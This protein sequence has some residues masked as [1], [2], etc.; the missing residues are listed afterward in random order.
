MSLF[1]CSRLSSSCR[2]RWAC[3]L[4][5]IIFLLFSLIQSMLAFRAIDSHYQGSSCMRCCLAIDTTSCLLWMNLIFLILV[6]TDDLVDLNHSRW[7]RRARSMISL[8][9]PLILIQSI[10]MQP[11]NLVAPLVVVDTDDLRIPYRCNSC[12]NDTLSVWMLL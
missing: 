1:G 8:P 4:Q 10:R 3:W 5:S 9:I 11:R 7:S 12:Y 2:N 6:H